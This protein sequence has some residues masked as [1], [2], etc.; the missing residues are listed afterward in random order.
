MSIHTAIWLTYVELD[1]L[2]VLRKCKILSLYLVNMWTCYKWHCWVWTNDDDQ[3][4]DTETVSETGLF[5]HEWEMRD[6]WHRWI[7]CKY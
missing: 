2:F 1:L 3:S 7:F 6:E 5:I 4:G